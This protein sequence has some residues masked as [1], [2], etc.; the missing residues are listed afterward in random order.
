MRSAEAKVYIYIVP[1]ATFFTHRTSSHN[2]TQWTGNAKGQEEKGRFSLT[3]SMAPTLPAYGYTSQNL[4]F[5][6]ESDTGK[7]DSPFPDEGKNEV[8]STSLTPLHVPNTD[9][10]GP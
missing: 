1:S 6:L 7:T 8:Y 4:H 9:G 10:V 3:T 2:L 5:I